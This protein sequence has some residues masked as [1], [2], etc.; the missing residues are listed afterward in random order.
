MWEEKGNVKVRG[1]KGVDMD[2]SRR[3]LLDSEGNWGAMD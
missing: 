3:S 1:V 2:V